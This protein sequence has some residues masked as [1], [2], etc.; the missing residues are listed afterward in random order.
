MALDRMTGVSG[1]LG[2]LILALILHGRAAAQDELPSDAWRT[3]KAE[4]QATLTTSSQQ[5]GAR[6][7]E[8]PTLHAMEE[9]EDREFLAELNLLSAALDGD[10]SADLSK[11]KLLDKASLA[12]LAVMLIDKLAC[13]PRLSV[14]SPLWIDARVTFGVWSGPQC[15]FGLRLKIVCE[16]RDRVDTRVAF[17]CGRQPQAA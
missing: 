13:K 9:Q 4:A 8:A 14:E 10:T 11:L 3:W 1:V 12:I 6:L 15:T 5:L 17:P 7:A 16:V 2:P